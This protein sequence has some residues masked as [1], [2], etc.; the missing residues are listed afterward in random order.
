MSYFVYEMFR[1]NGCSRKKEALLL[2]RASFRISW[3]KRV[4]MRALAGARTRV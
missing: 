2:D 4:L 1:F 3:S